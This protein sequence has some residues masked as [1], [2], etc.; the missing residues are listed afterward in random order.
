M[1]LNQ[2]TE[3]IFTDLHARITNNLHQQ[4]QKYEECTQIQLLIDIVR[5]HYYFSMSVSLRIR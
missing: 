4:Q 5:F 3:Q 1:I 2:Y